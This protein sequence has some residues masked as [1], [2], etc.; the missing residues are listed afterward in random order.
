M[1]KIERIILGL[2]KR[3]ERLAFLLK[4][5]CEEQLLC[6]DFCIGCE[7]HSDENGNCECIREMNMIMDEVKELYEMKRV[8]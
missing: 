4:A 8:F 2:K 7:E 5:N 3:S 6:S 1:D